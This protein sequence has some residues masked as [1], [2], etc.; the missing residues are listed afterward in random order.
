MS[1]NDFVFIMVGTFNLLTRCKSILLINCVAVKCKMEKI[2]QI[3]FHVLEAPC[4]RST[5]THTEL[6]PNDSTAVCC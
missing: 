4:V 6:E 3:K 5:D 1:A 2:K